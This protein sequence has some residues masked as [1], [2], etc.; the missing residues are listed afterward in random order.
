[1]RLRFVISALV[2]VALL[3]LILGA[4][5]SCGSGLPYSAFIDKSGNIK[6]VLQPNQMAHSFSEGLAAVSVNGKWGFINT[7]GRFV[8]PPQFGWAGDFSEGLALVTDA[9]PDA[10]WKKDTLFGYIDI[11]G[12]YAIQPR[13]NWADSFSDG[14]APVCIGP[15]RNEGLSQA[16]IG[17]IGHD[18]AFVLPPRYRSGSRFSEG[19]AGASLDAFPRELTGFID[20]SGRFVIAPRFT[21]ASEFSNGLAATDRGFVDHHGN[22]V[23][24]KFPARPEEGFSE[25]WAAVLDDDRIVFVDK[26]G[27]VVLTPQW[28]SVG[29]FSEG[30]APACTSNCGVSAIGFTQHWGYIDRTGKFVIEPRLGYGP[31]PFK[32][33]L[34]LVCFGCKG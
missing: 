18:G 5:S 17:Y 20:K 16:R 4:L 26:S 12:K 24:G 27:R 10:Y 6:I 32:N 25:E 11:S 2:S 7:A 28:E 34:A 15:C 23:I 30:L 1:M 19:L 29:S 31:K 8:I 13:F 33:G 14:L 9:Q 22:V 3:L 21:W